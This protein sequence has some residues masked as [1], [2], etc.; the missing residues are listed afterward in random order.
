MDLQEPDSKNKRHA[1]REYQASLLPFV[2]A[3]NGEVPKFLPIY[4]G[5]HICSE[6][7]VRRFKKEFAKNSADLAIAFESGQLAHNIHLGETPTEI[8]N[9]F[10]N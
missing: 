10:N 1:L 2:V 9:L 5:L 6:N 3:K 8:F 4:R 7:F